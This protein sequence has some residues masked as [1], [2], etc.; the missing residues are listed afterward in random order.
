VTVTGGV[1]TTSGTSAGRLTTGNTSFDSATTLRMKLADV[2][3][4]DRLTVNGTVAIGGNLQ[5]SGSPTIGVG[6]V[7][8]LID[9]DGADAVTG[10]FSGLPEGAHVSAG[11]LPFAISYVGGSGNDV[12]LTRLAMPT[13]TS[14]QIN[15]GSTQRSRLT[16]L[17]V[18]FSMQVSFTGPVA[19]AFTLNRNGGG[20]V[21]FTAMASIIGGVT[22]VTLDNF[23][24]SDTEFGSLIDGRYTLMALASQISAG[25]VQLNN[26]VN[27]TFGNAQALFRFFGD[28]NGDQVVNG[29]DLGFFRNTFGTQSGDANY[30]SY[31]DINGDGVI[32]GFDLG[33]FR[34][35]FGTMLP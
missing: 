13:V 21:A 14:T 33:Q 17:Q 28:V 30:L 18:T 6:S 12:V 19:S 24:G 26:G 27:Y 2:N 11:G 8:M 20:S 5:L 25:G 9:N 15:D 23:T 29:L 32:N 16:S 22:V 35:R 31:L 3:T 1:L 10:T 4:S 34:T 7:V